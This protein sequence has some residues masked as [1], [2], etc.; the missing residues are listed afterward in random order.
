MARDVKCGCGSGHARQPGE[1]LGLCALEAR[2]VHKHVPPVLED[3]TGLNTRTVKGNLGKGI[4]YVISYIHI[5]IYIT[6]YIIH[7]IHTIH[8]Q[9][10]WAWVK[11][12]Y[13]QW[14]SGKWTNGLKPAVPWWFNFDPSPYWVDASLSCANKSWRANLLC[15]E[16]VSKMA[17]QA[18]VLA[19]KFIAHRIQPSACLAVG[20]AEIHADSPVT[21]ASNKI[22]IQFCM[23]VCSEM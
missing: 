23:R 22:V 3:P 19:C 13:P 18:T 15:F 21:F 11:N 2:E 6:I 8:I 14:I 20:S 9:Y 16:F 17:S 1:I 7:T 5:Y 4:A 12:R 10:T